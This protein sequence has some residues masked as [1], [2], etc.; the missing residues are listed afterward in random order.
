MEKSSSERA[1]TVRSATLSDILRLVMGQRFGQ[2]VLTA[3]TLQTIPDR[4]AALATD[5][6][7]A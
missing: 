7:C 6:F 3:N 4:M 2:R 1:I 5:L